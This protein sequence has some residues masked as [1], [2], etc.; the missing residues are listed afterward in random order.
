MQV[1]FGKAISDL[2]TFYS[3]DIVNCRYVTEDFRWG[4]DY[5]AELFLKDGY[6]Q[7][8]NDILAIC[9]GKGKSY[10]LRKEH[11]CDSLNNDSNRFEEKIAMQMRKQGYI[12]GIGDIL[13]YQVPLKDEQ[14]DKAGKIDL[15]AYDKKEGILRILELK[16]PNNDNDSLLRCVL[17]GETY[18]KVLTNTKNVK[19][20]STSDEIFVY[21]IEKLKHNFRDVIG[22]AKKVV[23]CPVIFKSLNCRAYREYKNMSEL[24]NVEKIKNLFGQEII[25]VKEKSTNLYERVKER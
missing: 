4:T 12:E 18:K 10:D 6:V 3:K 9:R 13:D 14:S 23:A 24:P 2:N 11:N 20:S 16:A 7:R 21:G 25:V 19:K 17:E 1:E 5:I 8:F 22:T 15:L